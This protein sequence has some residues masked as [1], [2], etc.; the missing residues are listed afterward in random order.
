MMS[1]R[2]R[3]KKQQQA[4]IS[5]AKSTKSKSAMKKN[6]KPN[7]RD[8]THDVFGD[9]KE[10]QEVD[11]VP[12]ILKGISDEASNRDITKGI[13]LDHSPSDADLVISFEEV[14]E[15]WLYWDHALIGYVIDDAIPFAAMEGFIRK[16]WGSMAI[17]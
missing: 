15:E 3:P 9:L 13:Q 2:G 5:V 6:G 14:V 10:V 4:Q 1:G 17:P 8:I 11:E 16:Q 7:M 12:A